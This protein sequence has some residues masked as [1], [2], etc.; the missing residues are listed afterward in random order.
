MIQKSLEGW[1]KEKYNKY[2]TKNKFTELEKK[3][4]HTMFQMI[5]FLYHLMLNRSDSRFV[6]NFLSWQKFCEK[7][8]KKKE[9]KGKF[10]K[11]QKLWK[12]ELA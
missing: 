6:H 3:S 11:N 7:D 12:V 4:S 9:K 8:N 1:Q 10:I 2:D 5:I